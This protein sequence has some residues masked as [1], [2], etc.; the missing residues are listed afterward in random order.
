MFA[1]LPQETLQTPR[2]TL[3]PF[4]REDAA[5]NFKNWDSLPKVAEFMLWDPSKTVDDS[6]ARIE[7]FLR[8]YTPEKGFYVYAI[9]ETGLDEPIG[10]VMLGWIDTDHHSGEL[11]YML[12]P[13]AQGKGYMTEA[14]SALLDFAFGKLELNRV[15]ADCFLRNPASARVMQKCGM[16]YE[17]LMRGLYL[18]KEGYEDLFVYAILRSDWEFMKERELHHV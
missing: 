11:V 1:L 4:R 10:A 15:Q 2:L 14:V 16:L 18:G 12:S 17:G 5:A 13:A 3:R 6:L 8:D 9:T 7:E